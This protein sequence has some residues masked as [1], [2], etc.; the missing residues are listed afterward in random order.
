MTESQSRRLIKMA[1]LVF[2]RQLR[3][4]ESRGLRD[5][6]FRAIDVHHTIPSSK[7]LRD[8]T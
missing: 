3:L 7:L 2:V 6:G 4:G 1:F 5:C 8:A